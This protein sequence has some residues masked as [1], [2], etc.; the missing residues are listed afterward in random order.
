MEPMPLKL[1]KSIAIYSWS[2]LQHILGLRSSM[3]IFVYA[4][5]FLNIFFKQVDDTQSNVKFKE[6]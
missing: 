1:G 5:K 2:L 6:R 3:R 4:L